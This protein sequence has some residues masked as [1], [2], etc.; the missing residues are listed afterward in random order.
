MKVRPDKR[1]AIVLGANGYLGRH[2]VAKLRASGHTVRL[3]DIHSTSIDGYPEYQQL[4]MTD[5]EQVKRIDMR[6]EWLFHFA[7]KT[8]THQSF[9]KYEEYVIGN[10]ITLLNILDCMRSVEEPPRIVFPSSRLV[11]EGKSGKLLRESDSLACLT[12]YAA[13]KIACERYLAM[14]AL[15]YSIPY[16]IFRICVPYGNQSDEAYSFGTIGYFLERAM[17]GEAITLFGNGSSRRTFTHVEDICRLILAA[18]SYRQ[19][20]NGIF[21][22]GGGDHCSLLEA[23]Q[24]IADKYGVELA[25]TEW[26]DADL[27]IE[28]GDTMFDDSSLRRIIDVEYRHTLASW[29]EK[30]PT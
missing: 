18:V 23:A 26:P 28:S 16:S 8:G 21:N 30:L 4:D 10:E 25:F 29:L 3:Y 19:S 12:V 27:R 2:L 11:Y 20:E 15:N 1:T 14:Y 22:I 9:D 13:N 5:K 24:L 6:C 17:A 7:G